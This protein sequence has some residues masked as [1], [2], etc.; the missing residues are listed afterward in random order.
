ME[1]VR[2]NKLADQRAR[3]NGSPIRKRKVPYVISQEVTK[4]PLLRM[5]DSIRDK[6]TSMLQ[7]KIGDQFKSD[8]V[9]ALRS[10]NIDSHMKQM[11]RD[12]KVQL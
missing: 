6:L 12:G 5:I 9:S 3:A 10:S 4:R 8:I 1:G 7:D 2:K 11:M